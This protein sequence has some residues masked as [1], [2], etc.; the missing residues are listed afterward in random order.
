MKLVEVDTSLLTHDASHGTAMDLLKLDTI[1]IV[2]GLIIVGIYLKSFKLLIISLI[3]LAFSFSLSFGFSFF[4]SY[5]LDIV[6]YAP[7]V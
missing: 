2:C 7:S 5:G 6:T 1:S 3:N 4:L